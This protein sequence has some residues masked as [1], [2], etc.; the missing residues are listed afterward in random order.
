MIKPKRKVSDFQAFSF[1]FERENSLFKKQMGQQKT[2]GFIQ[3][4]GLPKLKKEKDK[5]ISPEPQ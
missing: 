3:L 4:S 2:S 5:S 1:K